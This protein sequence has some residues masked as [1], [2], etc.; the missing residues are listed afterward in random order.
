[1]A[2]RETS[3]IEVELEDGTIDLLREVARLQP[4]IYGGSGP[5]V[6]EYLIRR[7][8]DDLARAGLL[9]T[10]E[11]VDTAEDKSAAVM[12]FGLA[13]DINRRVVATSH[14]GFQEPA[15]RGEML[16]TLAEVPQR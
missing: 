2:I 6:A 9:P 7:G 13:Q 11:E 10:P 16:G 3:V 14:F 1:M 15:P 4:R 5:A 12:D 8:L